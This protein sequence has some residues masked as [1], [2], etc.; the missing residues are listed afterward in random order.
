MADI[1]QAILDWFEFCILLLPRLLYWGATEILGVA[2]EHIPPLDIVDPATLTSGFTGDLVYF[3]T[4]FEFSYG[5]GAICS[6]LLAR[7]ILRRIPL[8][9]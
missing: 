3:L 5:M 1:F 6:A 4:I 2:M 9:G 8:I 7:F